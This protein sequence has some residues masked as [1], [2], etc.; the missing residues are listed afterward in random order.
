M[1][2]IPLR[3][4][5]VAVFYDNFLSPELSSLLSQELIRLPQWE[6]KQIQMYDRIVDTPRLILNMG[7]SSGADQKEKL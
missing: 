7:G 4:E 6:T 3:R 1:A 5:G 2:R